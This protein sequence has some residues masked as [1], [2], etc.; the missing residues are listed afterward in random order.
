MKLIFCL[1]MI[2]FISC[3]EEKGIQS[4]EY[5]IE[6]REIIPSHLKDQAF[7]DKLKMIEALPKS[8]DED[9]V[10]VLMHID[11]SISRRYAVNT[12]CLFKVVYSENSKDTQILTTEEM[13][14]KELKIFEN[15]KFELDQ[16]SKFNKKN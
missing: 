7:Q 10:Q 4:I 16:K 2:F 3:N 5:F 9:L 14:S 11:Y 12:L 15:L 1:I 6:Y 8:S 13:N